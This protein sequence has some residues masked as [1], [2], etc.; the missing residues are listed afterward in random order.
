MTNL[1]KPVVGAIVIIAIGHVEGDCCLTTTC[2]DYDSYK[3]L[4][5]AVEF[6][7]EVYGKTGWNSDHGE[8]YYKTGT[9]VAFAR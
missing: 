9:A 7:G 2:P 4:P 5:N 6:G 1:A 3:Q 8:A